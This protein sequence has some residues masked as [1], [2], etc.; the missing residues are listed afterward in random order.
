[1]GEP[2]TVSVRALITETLPSDMLHTYA[3]E[4]SGENA[5]PTDW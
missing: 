3:L 2:I 5:I 4:L 1:M